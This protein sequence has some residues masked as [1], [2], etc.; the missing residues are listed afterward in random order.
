MGGAIGDHVNKNTMALE[1]TDAWVE[2]ELER[3][4][5]QLSLEDLEDSDEERETHSHFNTG[6]VSRSLPWQ[7]RYHW[8]GPLIVSRDPTP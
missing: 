3:Q 2:A 5:Q 1:G 6:K 4:L 7:H 8:Q